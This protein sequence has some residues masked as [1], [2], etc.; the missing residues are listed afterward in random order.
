MIVKEITA[1]GLPESCNE[2]KF[3]GIRTTQNKVFLTITENYCVPTDLSVNDW[4]RYSERPSWC[5]LVDSDE[6]EKYNR[7][8][9]GIGW[10]I[11]D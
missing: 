8:D 5:P 4:E 10:G 3:C 2:C 6:K 9:Y 11:Y 1:I 7:F